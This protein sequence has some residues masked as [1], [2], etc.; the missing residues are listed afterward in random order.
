MIELFLPI[1]A[2]ACIIGVIVFLA[3]DKTKSNKKFEMELIEKRV[4]VLERRDREKQIEAIE[5]AIDF[6]KAV[7][8][9]AQKT[10]N[11]FQKKKSKKK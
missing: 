5:R 3:F 7:A 11:E 10:A 2:A 1:T 8:E 6:A 9:S 4:A